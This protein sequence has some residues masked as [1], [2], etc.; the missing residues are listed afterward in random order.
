MT[1]GLSK[2]YT[3]QKARYARGKLAI[4]CIP[5]GTGWKTLAALIISQMPGVAYSNRE[6]SYIVSPSRAAKFEQEIARIEQ[7]RKEALQ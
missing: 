2:T 5:D 1:G 6:S 4:H 7:Q 3:I